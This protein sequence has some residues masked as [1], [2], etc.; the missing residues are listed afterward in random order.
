[1]SL[2]LRLLLLLAD[3]DTGQLVFV[4]GDAPLAVEVGAGHLLRC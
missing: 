1:M 2:F 3:A 4:A